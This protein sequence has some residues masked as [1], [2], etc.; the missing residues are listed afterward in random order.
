MSGPTG[1]YPG[2]W[3]VRRVRGGDLLRAVRKVPGKARGM[4]TDPECSW[5]GPVGTTPHN[6]SR[7][8]M[9]HTR[10]TGHRTRFAVVEVVEYRADAAQRT[11]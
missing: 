6:I 9:R 1:R 10:K 11:G 4:C 3:D 5:P 7:E 8:C 2:Q